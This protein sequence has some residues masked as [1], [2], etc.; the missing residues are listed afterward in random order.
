MWTETLGYSWDGI[1]PYNQAYPN[2]H[3]Q[4]HQ[5]NSI[6][7]EGVE[8]YDPTIHDRRSVIPIMCKGAET[9]QIEFDD[10][11]K[12]F[13]EENGASDCM[14]QRHVPTVV[15]DST[16]TIAVK[17]HQ[18]LTHWSNNH[19]SNSLKARKEGS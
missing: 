3:Q 11:R 7:G 12:G 15:N 17:S 5:T 2:Q 14:L 6:S 10:Q 13:W 16:G 19:A 9:S 18:T 8:P 4:K 1:R